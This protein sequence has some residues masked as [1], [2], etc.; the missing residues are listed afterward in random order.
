MRLSIDTEDRTGVLA[1]IAAAVSGI[2]TNILDAQARTLEDGQGLIEL[3]IEI[4]DTD[5]LEKVMN[6]LKRIGGVRDVERSMKRV[7]ARK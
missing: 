7:R 1:E 6:T 3:T 2:Q 4:A 5:H